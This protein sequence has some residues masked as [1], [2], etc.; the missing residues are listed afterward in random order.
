MLIKFSEYS[1]N[2]AAILEGKKSALSLKKKLKEILSNTPD[3]PTEESE[4]SDLKKAFPKLA[5][6]IEKIQDALEDL[7]NNYDDLKNMHDE[8]PEYDRLERSIEKSYDRIEK[9]I[10]KLPDLVES[11]D[12]V[13]SRDKDKLS[14]HVSSLKEKHKKLTDEA[15]TIEAEIKKAEK[16][17]AK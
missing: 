5:T 17:L 16:K 6:R 1:L 15:A 7:S 8:E 13:K 9:A 2:E 3:K 4:Y 12:S 10:E 14:Q 11:D